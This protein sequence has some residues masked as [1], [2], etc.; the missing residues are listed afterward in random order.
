MDKFELVER[1]PGGARP[2]GGRGKTVISKENKSSINVTRLLKTIDLQD[3]NQVYRLRSIVVNTIGVTVTGCN[4]QVSMD[5]STNAEWSSLAALYDEFRVLG[6]LMVYHPINR[7][8]V[9]SNPLYV[10]YDNDSTPTLASINDVFDYPNARSWTS[11]DSFKYKWQRPNSANSPVLWS[12]VATPSG[13][14]GALTIFTTTS[15]GS[16]FNVGQAIFEFLIEFRGR[17]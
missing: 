17:R 12:D 2:R 8:T 15:F 5:P 11:C 9:N 10:C 6:G 7:Y 1:N 3:N 13:S 16:T 14:K 4:Y